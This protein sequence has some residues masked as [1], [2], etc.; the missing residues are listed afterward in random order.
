MVH[1]IHADDAEHDHE[2]IQISV[3]NSQHVHENADQ[4]QVERK[5]HQVADIH[6]GNKAPENI[7]MLIDQCRPGWDAMDH[8]R[9]KQHRRDRAGGQAERQHGDEGAGRSG[10]VGR[11][12]SGYAGNG[13]FAELF[14]MLGQAALDAIGKKAGN[15]VGRARRQ[16]DQKAE[17]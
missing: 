2:R 7:G 5:Q 8:E 11:F 15:D 13:S 12:R 14:R 1:L 9:G 17:D 6:G 16:S 3:G 10:V 4:R